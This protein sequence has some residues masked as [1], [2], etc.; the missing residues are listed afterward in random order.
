M[1]EKRRSDTMTKVNVLLPSAVY[2]SEGLRLKGVFNLV[3]QL[4]LVLWPAAYA[5]ARRFKKAVDLELALSDIAATYRVP[6]GHYAKS[7]KRFHQAN[8]SNSLHKP[9]GC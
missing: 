5:S 4:T 2:F 8:F 3:M 9:Q 6:I 1:S 7:R